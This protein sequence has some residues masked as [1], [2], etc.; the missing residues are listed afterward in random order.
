MLTCQNISLK[1]ND[2]LIF[3]DIS[4]SLL[5]GAC[6][7]VRGHNG[8][9]KTSLLKVIATLINPSS[10][11]ITYSDINIEE[12]KDEYQYL[13]N[14]IGHDD[15]LSEELTVEENLKIWAHIYS[16][17][18]II[19][20]ALKHFE[21]EDVIKVKVKKLSKGMKRKVLL[22]KLLLNHAQVWLLDEPF[23]N[24]DEQG[25]ERLNSLISTKCSQN[26]IVIISTNQDLRLKTLLTLN[27]EDYKP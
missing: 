24:L 11:S 23:A 27:I 6:L 19:S 25:V 14:Y 2:T 10:G 15:T 7:I 8:S 13:L 12:V 4:F 9:G 16:T 5:P 22:C 17:E 1:R 21:L 3:S 20:A 26:G 18:I